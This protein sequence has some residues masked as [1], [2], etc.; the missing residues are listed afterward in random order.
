MDAAGAVYAGRQSV[1]IFAAGLQL[2]LDVR[3]PGRTVHGAEVMAV[4]FAAEIVEGATLDRLPSGVAVARPGIGAVLARMAEG[5]DLALAGFAA[6][7]L[8]TD[9]LGAAGAFHDHAVAHH[10]ILVGAHRV[11]I[12]IEAVAEAVAQWDGY[13]VFAS[14]VRREL[15]LQ[16][17][18][19]LGVGFEV[20]LERAGLVDA[21]HVDRVGWQ[22]KHSQKEGECAAHVGF[23]SRAPEQGLP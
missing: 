2:V 18:P 16:L 23:Q 5:I 4:E 12:D 22:G 1:V 17:A 10:T 13:K 11:V 8:E 3:E 19:G 14:G 21:H 9:G 15:V 7:A 6:H 20:V